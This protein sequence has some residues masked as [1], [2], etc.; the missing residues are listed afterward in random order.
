MNAPPLNT[1]QQEAV[2]LKVERLTGFRKL[3]IV[4]VVVLGGLVVVDYAVRHIVRDKPFEL[5]ELLTHL[6]FLGI[7]YS[8]FDR[9]G[10]KQWMGDLTKGVR[11][12]RKP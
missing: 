1:E 10:A 3:R 6:M 2:R 9:D 12:W 11:T 8:I 5:V 4:A 7:A